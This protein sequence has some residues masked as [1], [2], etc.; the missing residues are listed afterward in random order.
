MRDTDKSFIEQCRLQ[1]LGCA[2]LSQSPGISVITVN[3]DLG[4][5]RK[6]KLTKDQFEREGNYRIALHI[7]STLLGKGLL[8][9]S[10]FQRAKILLIEKYKPVWGHYPDIRCDDC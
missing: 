3:H 9:H 6:M 4:E 8:S 7:I 1:N 2:D 5:N 10:E